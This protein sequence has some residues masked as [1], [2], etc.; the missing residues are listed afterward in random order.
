MARPQ[1]TLLSMANI[2]PGRAFTGTQ[3]TLRARVALTTSAT[4]FAALVFNPALAWH[5]QRSIYL[6]DITTPGDVLFTPV[7]SSVP[8]LGVDNLYTT[9]TSVTLVGQVHDTSSQ[10]FSGHTQYQGTEVEVI[11]AGTNLNRGG[12]VYKVGGQHSLNF[13]EYDKAGTLASK[14]ADFIKNYTLGATADAFSKTHTAHFR[15]QGVHAAEVLDIP[16]YLTTEA[17][18]GRTVVGHVPSDFGENG[19]TQAL[20]VETAAGAQ[21]LVLNITMK[22]R[23]SVSLKQAGVDPARVRAPDTLFPADPV[24]LARY[25]NAIAEENRIAQITGKDPT[26]S[27]EIIRLPPRDL[28]RGML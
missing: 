3:V 21:P 11:Y 18:L 5:N 17:G 26:K 23:T 6:H 4:G 20:L 14:T 24:T 2:P 28:T 13:M 27:G 15:P 9:A 8:A 1:R 19:W 7:W 16:E 12:T 10:S 22:Y 25:T